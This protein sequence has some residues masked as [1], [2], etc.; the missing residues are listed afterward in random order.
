MS[1]FAHGFILDQESAK[2]FIEEVSEGDI[3]SNF[4][5][6]QGFRIDTLTKEDKMLFTHN[7]LIEN[8]LTGHEKTAI[9]DPSLVHGVELLYIEACKKYFPSGLD[10]H[11]F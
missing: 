11:I 10:Y 8:T 4:L 6:F 1:V 3:G 5:F 7:S 9:V 2:A